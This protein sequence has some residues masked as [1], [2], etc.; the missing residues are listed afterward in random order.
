MQ[1]DLR[2]RAG[3][4]SRD[5][6]ADREPGGGVRSST[7]AGEAAW[8]LHTRRDGRRDGRLPLRHHHPNH[9]V[10]A[11]APAAAAA[12]AHAPHNRCRRHMLF[13]GADTL[14]ALRR[15]SCVRASR[16]CFADRSSG[17]S[18][19]RTP[20]ARPARQRRRAAGSTGCFRR[21]APRAPVSRC[22]EQAA[23][24]ASAVGRRKR[25]PTP[26]RHRR[27]RPSQSSY[28]S[29]SFRADRRVP[30]PPCTPRACAVRPPPTMCATLQGLAS[31]SMLQTRS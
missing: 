15:V 16:A 27:R 23:S 26:R 30:C 19:D 29:S 10:S 31:S 4:E 18:A 21:A 7:A 6:A 2:V 12:P 3:C 28:S 11:P 22:A 17:G 1:P 13:T 14:L 9:V 5:G 8:Q 20:R 24:T 25:V